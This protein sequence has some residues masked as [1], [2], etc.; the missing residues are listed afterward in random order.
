VNER[1]CVT[2]RIQPRSI[3]LKRTDDPNLSLIPSASLQDLELTSVHIALI[4]LGKGTRDGTV[5]TEATY[6]P[7][8][9]PLSHHPRPSSAL[10][11]NHPPTAVTTSAPSSSTQRTECIWVAYDTL[12]TEWM[13]QAQADD[14]TSMGPRLI[15]TRQGAAALASIR[16]AMRAAHL[17]SR[18]PP[19]L[20][21]R[22]TETLIILCHRQRTR[23]GGN[24]RT[25][26]CGAR[27]FR[28]CPGSEDAVVVFGSVGKEKANLSVVLPLK[29]KG[30]LI[31]SRRADPVGDR[32]LRLRLRIRGGAHRRRRRIN[33]FLSLSR[34]SD[35][36]ADDL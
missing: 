30:V 26:R 21:T 16:V 20:L 19:R 14:A 2:S 8:C 36:G 27:A 17:A 15:R 4:V 6:H 18:R 32:R 1:S 9:S 33:V 23:Y 24:R 31:A 3:F 22:Q 34:L 13:A 35:I 11:P 5:A 28:G 25:T 7:D 29:R 10:L 12:S